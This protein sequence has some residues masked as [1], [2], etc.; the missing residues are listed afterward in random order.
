[1]ISRVSALL[2]AALMTLPALA[3]ESVGETTVGDLTLTAPFARATLP[4]Q[5]VG[6]AYLI[7]F[8]GGT[9]DDVLVAVEAPLA[10]RVE[11]H[12]MSMD[13]ERMTMR[14]L[15]DGLVIPAGE[16]IA[17]KPGGAH[18]MLMELA[19]PLTTG[20]TLELTLTFEDAGTVILEVP[21]LP[22][23]AKQP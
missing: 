17:L 23:G 14:P 7:I 19:K 15:P 13:G 20:D 18:L 2:I 8:N 16:T 1:M 5:P 4:N 9:R 12:E 3:G 11:V 22:P 10:A 6:G 21:I